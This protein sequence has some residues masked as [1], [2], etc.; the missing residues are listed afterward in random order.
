MENYLVD[1]LTPDKVVVKN[2]PAKDILVSTIKGEVNILA[3]HTH[4]ITNLLTGLLTIRGSEE[5]LHFSVENGICKI[6]GD[7]IT[8][9][10]SSSLNKDQVDSASAEAE[11]SEIS[12]SLNKTDNMSD[13]QIEDLHKRLE[14]LNS[15]IKLA[16]L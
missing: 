13:S 2:V 4:F 6:L 7:K 3:N 15:H 9:L 1:I 11:V 8:I 5:D 14:V 10:S 12:L 16:S